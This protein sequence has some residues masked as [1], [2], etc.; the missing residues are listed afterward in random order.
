MGLVCLL[1]LSSPCVASCRRSN[2]HNVALNEVLC[3]LEDLVAGLA[4]PSRL[5]L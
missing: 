2:K 3:L 5:A 1:R 4:L